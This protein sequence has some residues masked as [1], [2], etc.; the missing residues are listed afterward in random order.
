MADVDGATMNFLVP[1]DRD[2]MVLYYFDEYLMTKHSGLKKSI[3]KFYKDPGT[4]R[5]HFDFISVH[6]IYTGIAA[7]PQGGDFLGHVR[8]MGRARQTVDQKI[9]NR[10]DSVLLQ[11][12]NA[13]QN[14]FYEGVVLYSSQGDVSKGKAKPYIGCKKIL[15]Q[16]ST[17][18]D[19]E[20]GM[21]AR[22]YCRSTPYEQIMQD[23][24][25][26]RIH[27]RCD[28]F[29]VHNGILFV[30]GPVSYTHLTLPTIC[31]V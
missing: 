16:K 12:F 10:P 15:V 23:P 29:D 1:K 28:K 11:F 22:T 8:L 30:I 24:E 5:L 17:I 26:A 7:F 9:S 21:L 18:T 4:G 20:P 6:T 3:L 13:A 19:Q 25:M 2:I 27:E 31:S 14:G